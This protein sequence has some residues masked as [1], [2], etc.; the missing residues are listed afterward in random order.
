MPGDEPPI[1]ET[2]HVTMREDLVRRT[3]ERLPEPQRDVIKLRYGL[4]GNREPLPLQRVANELDMAP[5]DVRRFEEQGLQ[6]LSLSREMDSLREA[7]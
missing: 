3:V 5:K 7:A 2:V 4:N 1:E 6:A